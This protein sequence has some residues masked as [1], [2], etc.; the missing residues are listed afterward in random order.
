MTAMG[1]GGSARC[2]PRLS[3]AA[4][5]W[6]Y[7]RRRLLV[8]GLFALALAGAGVGVYLLVQELE[9]EGDAPPPAP[10]PRVVIREQPEPE[11]TSDLG[12]PAFATKNTTRVAGED[13]VGDAAGVALAV[14]PST[15]GLDG[16]AAVSLVN[17][18]D[19]PGGIAASS[20][21]AD[22][23]RAPILLTEEGELP[24]LTAD[25]LDALAPA[26]A[27]A[28]DDR[29]IFRIGDAFSPRGARAF[30][31][32]GSNPAEVAA[33]VARL[34]EEL[35]GEM[36]ANVVIASSD[37]PA[38]AM[39]A[40]AWAARSGDPVLFAQRESVPS[41]TLDLL[42]RYEEAAV[43][44]LGPPSAISDRVIER[45]Q[46]IAPS[47]QRI[48]AEDPVENSIEFARYVDGGFGWNINDPGHGFVIANASRPLDAAAAAPLSASGTWGP[49][50]VTDDAAL[51]PTSLRGY[52]LDLKP[53]YQDDP[54]RAVY[55]HAWIIGDPDAISVAFQAQ[56]D[57]LAEL[58]PVTSGSSEPSLDLPD[59]DPEPE[60]R[61]QR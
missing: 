42:R 18:D 32:E 50:L 34:R 5:R 55:N 31:L 8:V 41:P 51:V 25:A 4:V 13:P 14:F 40:A 12:F 21:V 3:F 27:P 26:G 38:L 47:A 19:W 37:E 58:A 53:G 45:I 2:G 29:Q 17:A 28:T 46:E 48:G 16:P 54:T 7:L 10:A 60:R 15:G 9:D 56:V 49:L 22:P 39:P 43:Y 6:V 61:R 33:E 35:T 24:E 44:V 30:E 20:L 1:A 52:L 57:E 36:P 59:L 11:A 23:V